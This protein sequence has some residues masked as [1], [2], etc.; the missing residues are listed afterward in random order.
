MVILELVHA[1][2][3]NFAEGLCL[4]DPEL[5]QAQPGHVIQAS[6]LNQLPFR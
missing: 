3:P 1:S 6:D 4:L 5:T 2:K